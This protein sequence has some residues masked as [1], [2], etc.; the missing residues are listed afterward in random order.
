M[1]SAWGRCAAVNRRAVRKRGFTL[2]EL[3]VVVAII[4]VLVAL[5]LPA[6]QSARE[7]ARRAQCANNLKQFGVAMHNYHDS[8]RTLP[9]A[10]Y[11]TEGA[12]FAS[13]WTWGAMVL[14]HVEQT[15]LFDQFNFD[16]EPTDAANRTLAGTMLPVFRCPSE[17]R[18]ETATFTISRVSSRGCSPEVTWPMANY[19]LNH[20]LG[21]TRFS[22]VQDGLSNTIMLGE[23]TVSET[24]WVLFS[25]A[26]STTAWGY[27]SDKNKETLAFVACTS[28]SWPKKKNR[29]LWSLCSYHPGGAQVTFFDG[30]VRLIPLTINEGTLLRLAD[31]RDGEPVGDF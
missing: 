18:A 8:H 15:G 24:G 10:E 11:G 20:L 31:P 28:V 14:P 4:G 13:G 16:L 7:S 21:E 30:H 22:D 6:V 25:L 5:L 29:D 9:L 2:V 19:G 26:V 12:L 17:A 3:L 27:W 23:N 1:E